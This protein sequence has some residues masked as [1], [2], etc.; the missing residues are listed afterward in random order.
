M[1]KFSVLL[2][3]LLLVVGMASSAM[4]ASISTFKLNIAD[5][6]FAMNHAL[7]VEPF[8]EALDRQANMPLVMGQ[9]QGSP[10]FGVDPGAGAVDA[11][12]NT[13]VVGFQ[14]GFFGPTAAYTDS[15]TAAPSGSVDL[16][17]DNSLTVDLSAWTAAWNGSTFNQG[18]SSVTTTFNSATGEFTAEWSSLIAGGPPFGGKTGYWA[19]NGTVA[20]VPEP[21]SLLLIGSGLAGLLG[22]ARRK[23]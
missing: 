15:G 9:H 20:A 19:M 3:S 8:N 2:A 7:D 14:F 1:K 18:S 6:A 4:S 22:L 21:A 16:S 13:G 10:G 5:F 12:V 23:K 11:S 17:V